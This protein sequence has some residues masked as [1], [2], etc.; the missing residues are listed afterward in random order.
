M[1]LVKLEK[2]SSKPAIFVIVKPLFMI[3]KAPNS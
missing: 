3:I 2:A 1:N